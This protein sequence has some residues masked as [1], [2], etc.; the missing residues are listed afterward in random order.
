MSSLGIVIRTY[1]WHRGGSPVTDRVSPNIGR[2]QIM[3]RWMLVT[4][5]AWSM[6]EMW[7]TH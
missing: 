4:G 7:P 6:I 2:E 5:K 3:Q 1:E